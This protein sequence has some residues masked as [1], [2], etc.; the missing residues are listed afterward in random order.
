MTVTYTYM[1]LISQT[2]SL[3]FK[4]KQTRIEELRGIVTKEDSIKQVKDLKYARV[5]LML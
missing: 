4:L 3:G 5:M 1:G 2:T